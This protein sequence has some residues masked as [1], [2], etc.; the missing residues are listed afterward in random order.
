MKNDRDQ[1]PRRYLVTPEP[2]GE[3]N[4]FLGSLEKALFG[5][6]RLVQLRSKLL[7][8]DDYMNL[9]RE[10]VRLCHRHDARLILNGPAANGYCAADGVHMTSAELM[11][12]ASSDLS[13]NLL[14]S[15]ACHNEREVLHAKDLGIDFVTVSPVL[16]TASHPGAPALG[17]QRFA[18]VASCATMPVFALGGLT[19][20]DLN[21]AISNGA[22]GIAAIRSLWPPSA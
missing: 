13:S 11:K 20:T 21:L 6:I 4:K 3:R 9:V 10:A 19:D 8:S 7:S 18:E 16:P 12:C 17:W 5:G 14:I 2:L 1:L 22:H 15:A